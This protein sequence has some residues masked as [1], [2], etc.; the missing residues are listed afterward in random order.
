MTDRKG[1]TDVVPPIPFGLK[2]KQPRSLR[3]T[4]QVLVSP[5]LSLYKAS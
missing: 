4:I 1:K 3:R 2:Y 5:G